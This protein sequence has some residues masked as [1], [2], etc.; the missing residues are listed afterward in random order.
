M[1]KF[2]SY[3]ASK[4]VKLGV[5]WLV[6]IRAYRVLARVNS[7]RSPVLGKVLN[8]YS[9]GEFIE[10]EYTD[11]NNEVM[12]DIFLRRELCLRQAT[13]DINVSIQLDNNY[14][15][16]DN[17]DKMEAN[18]DNADNTVDSNRPLLTTETLKEPGTDEV[19][20]TDNADTK[21]ANS[22]NAGNTIDLNR[23]LLN[24]ETVE[25]PDTD[26]A[27]AKNLYDNYKDTMN[28]FNE[29]LKNEDFTKKII[30]DLCNDVLFRTLS[31]FVNLILWVASEYVEIRSWAALI[32]ASL[33]PML[34]FALQ[35]GYFLEISEQSNSHQQ[36]NIPQQSNSGNESISLLDQTFAIKIYSIALVIILSSI[37]WVFI[38][39]ATGN[40]LLNSP[41]YFSKNLQPS[42]SFYWSIL[43]LIL[44]YFMGAV[45]LIC[46]D[47][48]RSKLKK[49]SLTN[50]SSSETFSK[51][52]LISTLS[53]YLAAWTPYVLISTVAWGTVNIASVL[54]GVFFFGMRSNIYRLQAGACCV[55]I[56]FIPTAKLEW[57]WNGCSILRWFFH[58]LFV[59]FAM[60]AAFILL[61]DNPLTIFNL[62]QLIW[63]LPYVFTFI[64]LRDKDE[65]EPYNKIRCIYEIRLLRHLAD[66][67]VSGK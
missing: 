51:E 31:L 25:E 57:G 60:I 6:P 28:K 48:T 45:C 9:N 19:K 56:L 27:K 58:G 16:P 4:R 15:A 53:D 65:R 8:I 5:G 24:I 22:D 54:I 10:C 7:N 21:E 1:S 55:L 39:L 33:C 66:V 11:E 42:I 43:S 47:F 26:E 2:A 18:S 20:Y 14:K 32:L 23:P 41:F 50:I 62:F 63:A 34:W 12:T 49:F 61:L 59:A 3:L 35:R 64:F 67:L 30:G 40:F 44:N 46:V 17:A 52:I 29:Y 38:G 36:S 13:N 37:C